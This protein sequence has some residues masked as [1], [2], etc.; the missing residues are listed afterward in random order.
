MHSS[1][2]A[3]YKRNIF[4]IHTAAVLRAIIRLLMN[5]AILEEPVLISHLVDDVELENDGLPKVNRLQMSPKQSRMHESSLFISKPNS[6]E[7][8]MI[9]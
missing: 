4:W 2:A 6:K 7:Q 3:S 9:G 5:Q 8:Y 1:P